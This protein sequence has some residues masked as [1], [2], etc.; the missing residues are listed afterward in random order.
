MCS[1][2]LARDD[3]DR[4]LGIPQVTQV[5]QKRGVVD[6]TL[7]VRALTSILTT[8]ELGVSRISDALI[9][10]RYVRNPDAV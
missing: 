3:D 6:R 7:I 9:R 5:V 10:N 1:L 8:V 2:R 4:S